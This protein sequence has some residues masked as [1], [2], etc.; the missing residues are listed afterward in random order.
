[1]GTC[2]TPLRTVMGASGLPARIERL[3]QR[4]LDGSDT[5]VGY[6]ALAYCQAAIESRGRPLI[7]R[8]AAGLART[9]AIFP[10]AIAD[11]EL[12]VGTHLFGER[13]G[14][15]A[16]FDFPEFASHLFERPADALR[17]ALGQTT[18]SSEERGQIL[19]YEGR[20]HELVGFDPSAPAPPD[21]VALAL[22]AEVLFGWGSCVNHSVRD[23]AKVL[24]CGFLAIA[25]QIDERLASLRMES[26][27]DIAQY[28]FL[29]AASTIAHAAAGLGTR[30]AE[31]ARRFAADCADEGRRK[32]LLH[33]ADVCDQVPARPARTLREA[34]QALWFAHTITC[35]EDHINA[36]SIGRLD[37]ILQPYYAADL[38]AGRITEEEAV[39]LLMLLN[40]KLYRD[41]DVQQAI[42]GGRRPDGSDATCDM[43]YLC[44]E[45][46]RR[47]GLVRCLSI[48]LHRGTP[49]ELLDRATDLLAEGGGIP[50]FFNDEAIIPALMDKGVAREDAHDYAVIGCVEI[51]IPGKTNPHAVS[52]QINLAKCLELALHS[53]LD[54]RTGLQA[55]PRTGLLE[56]HASVDDLW[57]AY[58]TQVEHF[59]RCGAFVSNAGEMQQEHDFPL[60][61]QSILTEACIDRGRDITSG[62]ALYNYH[63]CSAIGVPN[64]GDSFAA[65]E[66]LV[67]GD[68]QVSPRE[69]RQTLLGDFEGA[70]SLRQMLLRWSAK[71]G[72]DEEAP[73]RWAARAAQHYCETLSQFTTVRGGGFHAHLFSFVWH[74]DPFGRTTGALP[75]GRKAGQPLAYSLSPTQGRDEKGITGLMASLSKIP[76]HLAAAS[77][78]AIIE[79]TPSFFEGD[80]RETFVSLL[81]TA[82]ERGIGQM[83][84]NV[85]TAERLRKAQE[86]PERYG[87]IVVRV[88]GFSQRFSLLGRDMQDHIIARAKHSN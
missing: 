9:L 8:R 56:D 14:V 51:T 52:H 19:A 35:C 11:D 1:M 72:N 45:A 31:C 66:A 88:S 78:S 48:R 62:G 40:L 38:A 53:G 79:L 41:Y 23:Y 60:P 4:A 5:P 59:A 80:G 39:E 87:N 74:I 75:E 43:T 42:L 16:A 21:P 55:G 12:I 64:V 46:T 47:L 2:T 6:R 33:A 73:D 68:R 70:E 10:A 67:F 34:V 76:H 58:T 20:A 54:P 15:D 32:E 37:Q 85:V 71:Y 65:L 86:D 25:Q 63:S 83:Q 30:Y 81:R 49:R 28:S 69:L 77:S 17:A 13:S 26:P 61:Y 44:L 24:R 18:L 22:R 84:F 50:F 29:R 57:R 7:I 27:D 3:R 36:N 82:V